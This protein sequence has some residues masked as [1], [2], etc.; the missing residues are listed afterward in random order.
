MNKL[1]PRN[2]MQA[3]TVQISKKATIFPSAGQI[4]TILI[5]PIIS[6]VFEKVIKMKLDRVLIDKLLN[7]S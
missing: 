3:V 1:T 6:K 7:H 4:K 5:I 2:L